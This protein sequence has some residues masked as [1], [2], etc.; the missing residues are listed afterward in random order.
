MAF[1]PPAEGAFSPSAATNLGSRHGHGDDPRQGTRSNRA[2]HVEGDDG[3]ERLSGLAGVGQVGQVESEVSR[4]ARPRT[5]SAT[6]SPVFRGRGRADSYS[7]ARI[8]GRESFSLRTDVTMQ[9]RADPQ[10][11]RP[12]YGCLPNARSAC[13]TIVT[14][15]ASTSQTHRSRGLFP[16]WHLET[17][18]CPDLVGLDGAA[19]VDSNHSK[20][21]GQDRRAFRDATS[22]TSFRFLLVERSRTARSGAPVGRFDPE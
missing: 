19:W 16:D 3:V 13:S 6:S 8:V 22:P 4:T 2:S 11:F 1:A 9:T 21:L 20:N 14:N 7:N 5:R 12:K 10:A 15:I 18:N 17:V